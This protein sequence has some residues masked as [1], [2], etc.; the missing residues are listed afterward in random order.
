MEHTTYKVLLIEDDGLDQMAFKRFL[1]DEKLL[2]DYKIA[3]SVSEAQ[4]ILDS[5]K[6][7]IIV[8]D[9]SLGDGTALD[10]LNSVKNT[11]IILTT[12]VADEQVAIKAWR[13]GAYDYLPKDLD[14]NYLKAIPKAIE[15]AIKRKKTEQALDRKQKNLEAIFDAAPIGMLLADE[16]MIIIRV[17]S[18]VKQMLHR[19][20]SQIIN[21]EVD[22]ALDLVSSTHNKKACECSQACAECTLK[23]TIRSVLDSG[24]PI[25]HVEIHPT[26][27]IDN[28]ETPLWFRISAE[29]IIIDDHKHVLLAVDDITE[30]KKAEEEHR[31]ADEKYR[32]I[33]ENSAVAITVADDQE[34][35]V[36]WNSFWEGLLGLEGKDIY[37]RPIHSFYPPG[38]WERIRAF[39]VRKNGMQHHIETVMVKKDGQVINVD[40][41]LSILKNSEGKTTG[42]IGVIRD[43][44]ERKKAEEKLKETMELKSQFISNVSHELR[45]PLTGMIEG[46]GIVMDEVVGP[47]N[48]KQK[49]FLG[50]AKRNAERLSD[51]INNLL[52]FQR[53]GAGKTKLDIRI[54]DIKEVLSEVQETMTLF[55]KKNDIQLSFSSADDISKAEFDQAKVI[56]VLT[57]LV[58]NAIKFT[59][60]KGSV[61]VNVRRQDDNWVISVS[62]TGMGIPKEALPKIFDRFYRVNRRGKQIRGTGLG[63]AIVH[64]IVMIHSGRIEVES[65]VD[66]GTTFTVFLPLK[67]KS[68]PENS[69]EKED[70][71]LENTI[72]TPG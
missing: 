57:N 17:N 1:E 72:V 48:E 26:L 11:P 3:D 21:R 46:L 27:K 30:L 34:R 39:D 45:T 29:P 43:I 56:Q 22:S 2:Y 55:A 15:N 9:Y 5:E 18:V 7:D 36:S 59:P 53:L 33:F 4:S 32:T 16:N 61:S 38:E 42:S 31:L 37:L 19:E 23:K 67:A 47:I 12:G 52:D 65:Q 25:H 41:S 20:Y 13:A 44:T 35:L 64:K 54:N 10:I 14:R 62:D 71:L 40:I 70:E 60:E 50:I 51:L 58:S 66:Q 6:F 24:R 49:K 69:S 8:S 68:S 28:K 63:L